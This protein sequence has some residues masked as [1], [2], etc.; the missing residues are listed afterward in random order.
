MNKLEYYFK[1]KDFFSEKPLKI[2]YARLLLKC[3]EKY[4]NFASLAVMLKLEAECDTVVQNSVFC[5]QFT[6]KC[7]SL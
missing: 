3:L 6:L 7:D 5:Q 2:E 4:I 1:L